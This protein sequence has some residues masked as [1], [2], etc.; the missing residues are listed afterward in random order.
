[1]C[2]Y[3]VALFIA[4]SKACSNHIVVFAGAS[5]GMS[6]DEGAMLECHQVTVD[7]QELKRLHH[8]TGAMLGGSAPAAA[9]AP[10]E[11][12]LHLAYSG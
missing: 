7:C 9:S 4:F 10:T 5:V 2:N 11:T 6:T 1:M 8:L 12:A 3:V